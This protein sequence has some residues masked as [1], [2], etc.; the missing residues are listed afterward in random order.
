MNSKHGGW[1]SEIRCEF[2]SFKSNEDFVMKIVL[3][4]GFYKIFVD[5]KALSRTFPYR[6]P[7][8]T[9]TDVILW[10]GSNGFKWNKVVL[11]GADKAG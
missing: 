9:A 3:M 5:G 2:P 4:D 10:G 6:I 8:A 7:I 1:Q 11:P